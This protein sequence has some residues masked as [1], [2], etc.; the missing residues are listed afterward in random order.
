MTILIEN[1][2]EHLID[3]E[4][5]SLL[6]E[7]VEKALQLEGYPLNIEVSVTFVNNGEIQELNQQFRQI[8]KPTD[9]LSFP[10]LEFEEGD[11]DEEGFIDFEGLEDSLNPETGELVLGDI[12]ISVEKAVEQ[13]KAYEHSLKRE[14][15][16]LT[17]HSMFHLMGYDH[18][19]PEEEEIMK[20]KQE[21]VLQEVDLSR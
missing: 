4:M 5:R 6:H 16:F 8:D 2:T 19:T 3:E 1:N 14:I 15:G 20:K 13:A 9:V 11:E 18:M 7:I 17:A 21:Q 12:V 10:M